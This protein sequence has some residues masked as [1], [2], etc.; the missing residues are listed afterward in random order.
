ME[1][2]T[3]KKTRKP[4]VIAVYGQTV[5]KM[6]SEINVKYIID[7]C[8]EHE[9]AAKWYLSCYKDTTFMHLRKDFAE[10]FLG[11]SFGTKA[12]AME[13]GANELRELFK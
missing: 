8:K 3:V 2:A 7:Y 5:P 13:A 9:D 4:A 11:M 12:S 1:E 6:V 10:K